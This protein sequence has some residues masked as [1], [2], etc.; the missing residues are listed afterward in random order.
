MNLVR[1]VPTYSLAIATVA[2]AAAGLI[3][4]AIASAFQHRTI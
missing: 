4:I 1:Y 2:G 3:A